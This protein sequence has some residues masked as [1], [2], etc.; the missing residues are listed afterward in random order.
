MVVLA[1]AALAALPLARGVVQ[2]CV[3]HTIADL[4]GP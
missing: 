1:A 3:D 4:G 2:S